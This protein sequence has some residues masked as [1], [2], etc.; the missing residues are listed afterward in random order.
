MENW[1]VL[2][3]VAGGGSGSTRVAVDLALGHKQ[4]GLFEPMIFLRGKRGTNVERRNELKRKG[5][6]HTEVTTRRKLLLIQ[7]LVGIIKDFQPHVLD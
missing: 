7:E 6:K 5:I 1:R 4:N 3:A 2:H